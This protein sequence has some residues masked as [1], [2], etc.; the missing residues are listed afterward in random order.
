MF[1]QVFIALLSFSGSLATKFIPL[2]N[3]PHFTRTT[4]RPALFVSNLNECNQ[5]LCPY[6]FMINLDTCNTW[7]CCTLNDPSGRIC[8]LNKADGDLN[9]FNM[10][11]RI[12]ELKTWTIHI[13]CDYKCKFDCRKYNSEYNSNI[14]LNKI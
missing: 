13:L 6:L 12:N 10:I 5:G 8:I 4:T 3:Q 14:K 2:N 9:A 1:K 11:T 7:S